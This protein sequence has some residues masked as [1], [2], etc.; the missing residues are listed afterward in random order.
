MTIISINRPT[1]PG[2]AKDDKIA[3]YINDDFIFYHNTIKPGLHRTTT[4]N[5]EISSSF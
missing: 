1:L 5:S 2:F 3:A 4:S